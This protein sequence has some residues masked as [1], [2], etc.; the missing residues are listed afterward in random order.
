VNAAFG[1][2]CDLVNKPLQKRLRAEL[3]WI[4]ERCQTFGTADGNDRLQNRSILGEIWLKIGYI[5]MT[6]NL[7]SPRFSE[8]LPK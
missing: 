7:D 3:P 6:F 8:K 4:D 5:L 1:R 2:F